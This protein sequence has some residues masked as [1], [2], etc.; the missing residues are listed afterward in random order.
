VV[1]EIEIKEKGMSERRRD[2]DTQELALEGAERR[3]GDRRDSHRVAIEVEVKEGNEK[4]EKHDGNLGIGGVYFDRP[5]SLPIGSQ[6]YV[7]FKLPD[8]N[9]KIEAKGEVVEITSI[10]QPKDN[11]TRVRFV[12][13]DIKT[14]LLIARYLDSHKI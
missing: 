6:V 10:G 9:E 4:Y 5:L 8:S 14:E 1:P 12:D 11:G 7:R 13:L 2:D 3:M